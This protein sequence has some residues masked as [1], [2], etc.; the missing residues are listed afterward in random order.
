MYA[1]ICSGQPRIRG[2]TST[3]WTLC[4]SA[5]I[6]WIKGI[7]LEYFW[8]IS[9]LLVILYLKR[10]LPICSTYI[11]NQLLSLMRKISILPINQWNV[12]LSVCLFLN[13]SKTPKSNEFKFY[14]NISLGLQIV[15]GKKINSDSVN[16]LPE[17][18][19]TLKSSCIN[20]KQQKGKDMDENYF[21]KCFG[22]IGAMFWSYII[23]Y[24]LEF[25]HLINSHPIL[26]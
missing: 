22:S 19:H 15:L 12:C 18:R 24:E 17:N 20:P 5:Q 2:H 4:F 6:F 9:C 16:R 10:W 23:T 11:S 1:S 8:V 25:Y 26:L 21:L 3:S 14:D 13:S 7:I